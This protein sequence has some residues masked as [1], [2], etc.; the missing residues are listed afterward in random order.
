LF[1][2]FSITSV[3]LTAMYL[4]GLPILII[5]NPLFSRDSKT[6]YVLERGT[7]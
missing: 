3:G 7:F 6:S 5:A 1:F 2:I 4:T